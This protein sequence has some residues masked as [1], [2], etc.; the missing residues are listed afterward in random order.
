MDTNEATAVIEAGRVDEQELAAVSAR[1][2]ALPYAR[3]C[4]DC[5]SGGLSRR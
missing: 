2:E 4:I 1:L 3:L 5:K